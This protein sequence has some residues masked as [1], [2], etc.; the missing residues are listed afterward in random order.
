F[1]T[2]PVSDPSYRPGQVGAVALWDEQ[3]AGELFAAMRL[4]S[5]PEPV[6]TRAGRAAVTV[7][8]ADIRVRVF[9][10]AGT[11]GLGARAA[12]D[13]AARGFEVVGPAQNWRRSGLARTT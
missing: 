9:N 6:A 12:G 5:A 8:P 10:G 2:V 1:H 4:D 11:A 7:P 3:A 13:L